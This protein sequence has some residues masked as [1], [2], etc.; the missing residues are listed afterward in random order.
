[1][2]CYYLKE[3]EEYDRILCECMINK[4]NFIEKILNALE[5]DDKL[6]N[7]KN[8]DFFLKNHVIK[9]ILIERDKKSNNSKNFVS[10][11]IKLIGNL[12]K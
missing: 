7:N 10:K 5:H 11:T 3:N 6:N 4:T 12:F 2:Q 1:M 9:N 8:K